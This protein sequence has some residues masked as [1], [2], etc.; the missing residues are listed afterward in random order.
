MGS[1]MVGTGVYSF[2][3]AV[4]QPLEELTYR[5]IGSHTGFMC[6]R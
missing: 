5:F 4:R 6:S 1:R 3:P 2:P